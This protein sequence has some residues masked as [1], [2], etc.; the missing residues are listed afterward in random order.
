MWFIIGLGNPGEE[1][2]FT[3]HNVGRLFV[4]YLGKN[5]VFLPGKGDFFYKESKYGIL[6]IPSV[7]MNESGR[8]VKDLKKKFMFKEENLLVICDDADLSF[9]KP[10][11]RIK[12]GSGGH[13]GLSSI[14]YYLETEKFPRLRIGV[15]KKAPLRNYVLSEFKEDEKKFL[16]DNLFPFLKK[17]IEILN[18]QGVEKA[19]NY[20]NNFKE[21]TNE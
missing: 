19:M 18:N 15:G 17:G 21:V 1:Y 13:K 16:F 2:I 8:V 10:R 20:I 12:G 14:I 4:A 6:V 3:K 11:M 9:G 7:Y 5:K